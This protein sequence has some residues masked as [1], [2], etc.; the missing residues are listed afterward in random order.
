MP[1]I[2]NQ[3]SLAAKARVRAKLRD[4]AEGS[5]N[6]M[7][8]PRIETPHAATK[9][10]ATIVGVEAVHLR[11]DDRLRD[12]LRVHRTDLPPDAQP[13]ME[14]LGLRDI[15][16]PFAIDL[17]HYVEN[18]IG[19]DSARLRRGPFTP[20]PQNEEEWIERIMGM[21]VAELSSALA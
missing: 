15:A 13:L 2:A 18:R 10:L 14:R 8:V 1:T 16:D 6:L 20:Q 12:I 4:R 5:H 9:D 3:F 7:N 19:R 21:T 17:L 11:P